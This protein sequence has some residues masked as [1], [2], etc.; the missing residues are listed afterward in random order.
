[1]KQALQAEPAS[2]ISL[3]NNLSNRSA[4]RGMYSR[5]GELVSKAG[6]AVQPAQL[7]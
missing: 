1:L 7:F 3:M 2:K 4:L 5:A 6:G